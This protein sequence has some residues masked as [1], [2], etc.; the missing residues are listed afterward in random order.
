MQ[1]FSWSKAGRIF[2]FN[3]LSETSRRRALFIRGCEVTLKRIPER[4]KL[5]FERVRRMTVGQLTRELS[6]TIT[7][8]TSAS[9]FASD[10][11]MEEKGEDLWR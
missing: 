7:T 2:D 5:S 3:V 11:L 9:A 1:T 8:E 10:E 4:R 6:R